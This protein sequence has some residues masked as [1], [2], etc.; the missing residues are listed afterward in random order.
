MRNVGVSRRFTWPCN[1]ICSVT[2]D[3]QTESSQPTHAHDDMSYIMIAVFR[4]WEKVWHHAKQ[5]LQESVTK[6]TRY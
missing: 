4:N 5:V 3:V 6:I 2:R 1:S